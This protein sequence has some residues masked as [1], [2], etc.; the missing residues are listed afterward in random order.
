MSNFKFRRFG[1]KHLN[2]AL[3][4]ASKES[5]ESK[6]MQIKIQE[7]LENLSKDIRPENKKNL[8]SKPTGLGENNQSTDCDMETE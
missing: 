3:L 7:K 6:D 8:L 1:K 4:K 2:E 5:K